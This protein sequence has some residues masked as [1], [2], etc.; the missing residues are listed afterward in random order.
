MNRTSDELLTFIFD[1]IGKIAMLNDN[2][3]LLI[4]LAKMARDIAYADRCTIWMFDIK[5][6]KLWTKVAQGVETISIA[7]DSGIVGACIQSGES[8]VVN[9]VY[10]DKRFSAEI[11]KAT[12]YQTK[13]MMVIP[14]KN[15]NDDV[16]GAIQVINKKNDE[17]FSKLDLS[18]LKL[19]AT[20]VSETIKSTLLL[21][22]I[23]ST[24][25][26]LAHIIG[27]VGENRSQETANHVR[28]VSEYAYI[29]AELVGLEEEECGMLRDAAPLHDIGKIAISDAILNKPGKYNEEEYEEMKRHAQ[30]GYN[31]LKHSE[32]GLLKAGAIIAHEHHEK[33]DG[34]GYPRELQKEEIHIYGRIVAL[35]DVFDALSCDRVYKKG[36]THEEVMSYIQEEKGKYFDPLLVELLVT[37]EEKF[38]DIRERYKDVFD[39]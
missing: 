14:M 36:W 27:I 34:S 33:W 1:S 13:T 6:K 35:A 10:A 24:Q 32:R 21:E 23:E 11:D 28:R 22:E 31:M 25:K 3:K 20:Y 30:I 19:T 15:R 26:E 4:E 2:E 12:G 5:E 29:L 7:S 37:H 9:D 8:I 38:L 18:H 16:V 17:V 39:D